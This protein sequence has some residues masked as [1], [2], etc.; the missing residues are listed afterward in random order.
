MK[1]I[2]IL[3]SVLLTMSVFSQK[4]DSFKRI[5]IN[6]YYTNPV[7]SPDGKFVLLSGEHLKGIYLLDLNN[8]SVKQITDTEGS[9][10]AYSWD[11]SGD[12]FY[13]RE[14]PEGGYFSES[15]VIS[16]EIETGNKATESIDHNLLPSYHGK[17][18]DS[19]KALTVYTNPKT[20]KIEATDLSTS[21][22]WV[23]TNPEGQYYNAI[24]SNDK[25]KVAVHNGADIYIFPIDGST[26]G[27]KVGTGIATS[28]TKD[29]KYLLGFLDES[30][31][32][33]NVS[34]S[35]LYLFDTENAR[36]RKITNT[37]VIFEMY[38]TMHDNKLIFAD[39]K[40]GR[41]FITT[42]NLE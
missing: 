37:E 17:T 25:Q 26:A 5:E 40:S 7:F 39:D 23:V 12:S 27:K 13:Y 20:L 34:N 14:K 10:Y 6:G 36:T 21:E 4:I 3:G 1:K 35:D 22:S 30:E 29:D 9:G 24:L 2:I 15:K 41:L 33:H 28:W 31:D 32:G 18:N 16:Y 19:E 42:L 11:N 8:K 38:P